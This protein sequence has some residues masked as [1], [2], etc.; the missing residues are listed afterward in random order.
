[1]CVGLW[2]GV[3][4]LGATPG[5]PLGSP[6]LHREPATFS[7]LGAAKLRLVTVRSQTSDFDI[8]VDTT[9]GR[10]FRSIEAFENEAPKKIFGETDFRL[11]D[12]RTGARETNFRP[13]GAIWSILTPGLEKF[14]ILLHD[15]AQLLISP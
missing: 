11:M 10:H 9:T 14:N 6:F 15:L 8:F 13:A 2:L 1:V 3:I 4:E 12:M 7:E 5:N